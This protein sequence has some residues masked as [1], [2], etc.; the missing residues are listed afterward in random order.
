MATMAARWSRRD[1]LRLG[2]GALAG[3]LLLSCKSLDPG[4][5]HLTARPGTPT[6]QPTVG[7]SPLDLGSPRDGTL[8]VPHS[9][10]PATPAP[11]FIGL[12]GAGGSAVGWTSYQARAETRK[13]IMLAPDSRGPTWDLILN[14]EVGP[15]VGFIQKALEYTFAR[16]RI[17]PARICLGGFSDGASYGLSIGVANGDLFTHLVGY[18]P[19]YLQYPDDSIGKPRVFVSHGTSDPILPVTQSR[20]VIVPG[21]RSRG[22]DV[23]Y[24]EFAGVHEV[25]STISEAALDWFLA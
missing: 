22:Y 3:P 21:L 1:V 20:D 16:C 19:G 18:S 5:P 23:T 25:P 4:D 24:Q 8:Y 11:L 9:Y 2:A 7:I 17:D 14:G 6:I 12:H 10:D 13:M 15:D